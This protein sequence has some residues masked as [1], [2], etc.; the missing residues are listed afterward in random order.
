MNTALPWMP[1]LPALA[2]ST[3]RSPGLVVA[4]VSARPD[5]EDVARAIT[6]EDAYPR[7]STTVSRRAVAN[8]VAWGRSVL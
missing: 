5:V 7:I 3:A 1:A 4:R 8:F 2:L 6:G